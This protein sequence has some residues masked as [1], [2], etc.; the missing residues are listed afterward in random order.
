MTNSQVE[1]LNKMFKSATPAQIIGK[2]LKISGKAIVTTNFR[3]YDVSILHAV[4]SLAPDMPVIWCD[5][6]YN[7][8]ETY[9]HADLLTRMLSLNL[10]T[11]VPKQ[12]SAYRDVLMGV[13]GIDEQNH[14]LFTEQVKLEPFKR[15]LA[16][17][18]PEV[19][20]ANLRKGQTAF[21]DSIDIFSLSKDGVI[22]V[23]PFYNW[24][25]SDLDNYLAS[26]KLPNELEYYDPTK[27][28]SNRECG[29][30]N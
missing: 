14:E 21:R 27:A 7:T 15:A 16:Y 4:N 12:T 24:S 5:T 2:A 10:F 6:G 28:L 8:P 20:F 3:P 23:S 18:Q 30:H 22:K 9:K 29:L 17:H 25:D 19:W 1:A 11:Y 26:N 13:P